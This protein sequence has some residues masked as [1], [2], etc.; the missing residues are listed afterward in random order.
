M[1]HVDR[2]G[3]YII[4]SN[5]C[6]SCLGHLNNI[7]F[8]LHF[9]TR[10]GTNINDSSFVIIHT[11]IWGENDWS[12]KMR[13]GLKAASCWSMWNTLTGLCR[14]CCPNGELKNW[15][16][17]NHSA[18]WFRSTNICPS[19]LTVTQKAAGRIH[20]PIATSRYHQLAQYFYSCFEIQ[21]LCYV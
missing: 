15:L 20:F 18:A 13:R 17:E 4:T 8:H 2:V 3:G 12:T 14:T 19:C 21:F 10:N 11:D 16:K 5:Q 7:V 6:C 9:T 1:F